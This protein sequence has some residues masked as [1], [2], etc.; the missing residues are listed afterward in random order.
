MR[1]V[2]GRFGAGVIGELLKG[3]ETARIQR[4]SLAE[5]P[6]FG[7]LSHLSGVKI[8]GYISALCE[9]DILQTTEGQ[10]PLLRLGE[11]AR[12]VLEEGGPVIIRQ[13]RVERRAAADDFYDPALL[14][15]LRALRAQIARRQSVPAYVVFTDATLKQISALQPTTPAQLLEVPGVGESKLKRYGELFLEAIAAFLEEGE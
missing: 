12:A 14:Q 7:S 3:S 15:K 10:Y 6:L 8:K 2:R 4:F 5:N 1:S 13:K 11:G 9:Q